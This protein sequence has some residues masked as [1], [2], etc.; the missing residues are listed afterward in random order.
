MDQ[1]HAS[2][3]GRATQTAAS[4]RRF[5]TAA[6]LAIW[7]LTLVALSWL[8]A[9]PWLADSGLTGVV[10]A[11]YTPHVMFP[12]LACFTALWSWFARADGQR[13]SRVMGSSMLMTFVYFLILR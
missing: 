2:S 8:P 10:R 11:F 12:L 1:T 9:P 3:R 6:I 5:D 13:L 7:T 4:P